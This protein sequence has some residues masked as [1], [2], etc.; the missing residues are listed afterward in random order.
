MVPVDTL[1]V[2]LLCFPE[3]RSSKDDPWR[4]LRGGTYS[5]HSLWLIKEGEQ[6]HCMRYYKYSSTSVLQCLYA[7]KKNSCI[8]VNVRYILHSLILK[9]TMESYFL[10]IQD[11][12][13]IEGIIPI[14]ENL[15]WLN[16]NRLDLLVCDK[17]S[18][19]TC[20]MVEI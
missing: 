11:V 17:N 13:E 2:V 8:G 14:S 12:A 18:V 16:S 7:I 20:L 9:M 1:Y 19:K 10:V 4:P 15:R 5:D 6:S 3:F